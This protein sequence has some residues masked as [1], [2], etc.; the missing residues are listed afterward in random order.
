M[1]YGLHDSFRR[2]PVT[3]R[4][5]GVAHST[6]RGRIRE[7]MFCHVVDDILFCTDK[8]HR[9]CLNRFGPLRRIAQ[10]EALRPECRPSP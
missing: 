5:D 3:I 6:V 10:D 7:E 2:F 1:Q 9:S 4:V 8:G